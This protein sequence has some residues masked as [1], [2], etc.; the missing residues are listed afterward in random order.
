M[1]WEIGRAGE[2]KRLPGTPTITTSPPLASM[3]PRS[4]SLGLR[5]VHH[6]ASANELQ[7]L[8]P[9]QEVMDLT[10]RVH[11]AAGFLPSVQSVRTPK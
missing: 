5:A 10:A 9:P 2:T 7:A 3:G 8:V 4:C 6:L 11:D 1:V